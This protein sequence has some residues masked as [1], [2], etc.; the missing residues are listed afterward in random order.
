MGKI[1]VNV[2]I[3]I[4]S[5]KLEAL[6]SVANRCVA[7]VHEKDAGTSQY[8]WYLSSDRKICVVRET[9]DSSDALLAHLENLGP[10]FRDLAEVGELQ[11]AVFGEPTDELLAAIT[12]MQPSLYS[13]V[14]LL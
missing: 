6:K 1:G 3:R 2:A 10:L 8:D 11:I 12:E 9:Y 14:V 7:R 4:H 13:P 5:G